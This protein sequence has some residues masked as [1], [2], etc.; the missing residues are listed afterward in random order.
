M[1]L[2]PTSVHV[3]GLRE[4]TRDFGKLSKKLQRELQA[5]LRKLASPAADLIR[6]E[7]AGHGFSEGTLSGI[8]PGSR[9]GAAV[10]RQTRG[11]RTGS[12]PDFGSIQFR[13]AFLPGAQEAEPVVLAGVEEWLGRLTAE[14]GLGMG[15]ML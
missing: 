14:S 7:A 5:E 15:G 10:V 4:L 6:R 13:Y 11:K 12:R 8:R 2:F 1:A 3:E 9:L